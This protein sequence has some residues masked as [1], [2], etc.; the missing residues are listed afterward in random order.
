MGGLEIVGDLDEHIRRVSDHYD[1]LAANGPYGTLAP[2]NRGGRKSEYVAAVFDVALLNPLTQS[3]PYQRILDFGCGTGIFTRKAAAIAC[4]VVGM[5]ISPGMLEQAKAVCRELSNVRLMRTD[6][7]HVPLPD[8]SVD[9]VATREVLCYVPDVQL[10]YLLA[11]LRRVTRPGGTFLWLEQV[12]ENPDWQRNPQSPN[13]VKRS[14]DAIR[15][16]AK[17]SGWEV[18]DERI[19]RTPRFPWIYLVWFGLVPHGLIPTLARWE[20][21]WHSR[22]GRPAQRW[23]NCLFEL[24][25][26]AND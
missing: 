1:R 25:N 9:V 4:E 7:S 8:Q 10:P 5:N 6:G 18:L 15:K 23:W 21:A 22:R 13:L 16:T 11:E 20:V 3:A 17:D 2:H 12:S 14:S 19:V 26:P 24:R